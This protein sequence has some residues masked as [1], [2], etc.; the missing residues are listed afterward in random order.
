[1]R[2]VAWIPL[3]GG[4]GACSVFTDTS[5]LDEQRITATRDGGTRAP[6]PSASSSS[7][8]PTATGGTK[9][10][11][12]AGDAGS[13]GDTGPS[14]PPPPGGT[15]CE[16]SGPRSPT[17]GTGAWLNRSGAYVAGDGSVALGETGS[18]PLLVNGFGFALPATSQIK[19]IAME[20]TRSADSPGVGDGQLVLVAPGATP[21]ASRG[22]QK[23]YPFMSTEV[24]TYGGATDTWGTTLSAAQI[25][26]PQFGVRLTLSGF[27]DSPA[28]VDGVAL[29]V[30]YCH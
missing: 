19:G 15:Q 10:P 6:A 1:M 8:A 18:G 12:P 24:V 17:G 21:S 3:V 28:R 9:A 14:L 25:N 30:H 4:L 2:G 11:P 29:W 26:D 23:E 22:R 5:D 20:M 7:S 27:P 13:A 16:I